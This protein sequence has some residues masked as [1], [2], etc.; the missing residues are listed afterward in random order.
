MRISVKAR[1]RACVRARVYETATKARGEK[2][3][4]EDK[5]FGGSK[6]CC[7]SDRTSVLY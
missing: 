7:S 3:K 6:M 5:L 2:R 1:T 4:L